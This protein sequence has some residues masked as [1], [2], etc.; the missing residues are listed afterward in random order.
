VERKG[1]RPLQ[2][3]PKEGFNLYTLALPPLRLV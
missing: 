1:D 3:L 2:R